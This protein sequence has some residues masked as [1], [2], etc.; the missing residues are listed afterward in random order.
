M[1]DEEKTEDPTPRKLKKE[2]DEGNV[3]TAQEV[4][5]WFAILAM[6]GLMLTLVPWFFRAIRE[7]ARPFVEMAGVTPVGVHEIQHLMADVILHWILI[8]SVPFL[9]F[10]LAGV[11]ANAAQHGIQFTPKKLKPSLDKMNPLSNLKQRLSMKQLMEAVKSI[12]KIILISGA[13]IITM[14]PYENYF[15]NFADI[16]LLDTL[17]Y[18]REMVIAILLIVLLLMTI[19]TVIDIA[20]SYNQWWEKMK[21]SRTEVKE[22]TKQ[23]E[24]DPQVKARIR[25]LRA[26]RAR[27]R[28]MQAVPQADVVITN[29]TH[30]AVALRYEMETMNAPQLVAKGVDSLALRIRTVAE[31]HD[32]P[33][34][35]NPPLARALY[36]TVDLEQEIPTAHYQA[37]AEVIGYVMRLKGRLGGQQAAQAPRS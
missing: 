1:A 35:E 28:M 21:M 26:Q 27:E 20:V 32:V 9:I 10:L 36:D 29:P 34:V 7:L 11:V 22:E 31:E 6:T 25:S 13:V 5:N 12:L 37:V 3:F 24:G 4:A 17:A 33:I 16:A 18:L 15:H 8:L 2:R 30:Y 23:T 14:I 19:V